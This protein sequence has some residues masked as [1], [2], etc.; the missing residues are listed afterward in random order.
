MTSGTF[1][2]LEGSSR[3]T[4]FF[5]SVKVNTL[6]H[7]SETEVVQKSTHRT[8]KVTESNIKTHVHTDESVRENVPFDLKFVLEIS[9]FQNNRRLFSRKCN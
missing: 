4:L 3:L 8:H 2:I 7:K 6:R 1:G 5:F 9:C